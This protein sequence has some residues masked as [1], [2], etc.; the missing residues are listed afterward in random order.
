M[1]ADGPSPL[2]NRLRRDAMSLSVGMRERRDAELAQRRQD[3]QNLKRTVSRCVTRQRPCLIHFD[4][5]QVSC[6]I[7]I[8]RHNERA[9]SNAIDRSLLCYL[10]FAIREEICCAYHLQLCLRSML[11]DIPCGYAADRELA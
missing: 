3:L 9:V 6:N 1:P 10:Q 4:M 11:S 7:L 2:S 5:L 8:A